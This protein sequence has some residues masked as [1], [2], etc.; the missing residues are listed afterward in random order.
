MLRKAN[1]ALKSNPELWSRS[2]HFPSHVNQAKL[3][4]KVNC[5]QLACVS[6]FNGVHNSTIWQPLDTEPWEGKET[7]MSQDLPQNSCP[8]EYYDIIAL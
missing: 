3:S 8:S 4:W 6:M 7:A 1:Y 2:L 5:L